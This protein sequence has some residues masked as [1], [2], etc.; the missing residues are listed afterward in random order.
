VKLDIHSCSI[1]NFNPQKELVLLFLEKR[2][3]IISDK[4]ANS[5][6]RI[7]EKLKI[8]GFLGAD[9]AKDEI[10]KTLRKLSVNPERNSRVAKF[11]SLEGEYRSVL[12]WNYR[13]Y[14]RIDVEEI[15]VVDVFLDLENDVKL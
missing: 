5:I 6:K 8:N 12:A 13:I 14:Y 4:A 10:I 2:K 7:I 3:V 9:K 1:A 11:G 15:K